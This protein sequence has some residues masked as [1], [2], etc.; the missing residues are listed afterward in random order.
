M[1]AS[2]PEY[3]DQCSIPNQSNTKLTHSLKYVNSLDQTLDFSAFNLG[4][5]LPNFKALYVRGLLR[6]WVQIPFVIIFDIPSW[7]GLWL[8]YVFI[9]IVKNLN[10]KMLGLMMGP[11]GACHPSKVGLQ[12]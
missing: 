3:G 4:K 1:R 9:F 2:E 10:N 11:L 6:T 8:F 12:S 5:D 7:F